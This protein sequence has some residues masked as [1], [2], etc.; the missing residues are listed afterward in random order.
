MGP[1]LLVSKPSFDVLGRPIR[2]K[3]VKLSL[4]SFRGKTMLTIPHLYLAA[5]VQYLGGIRST[6]HCRNEDLENLAGDFQAT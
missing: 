6:I 2:F 3:G 1:N 5:S 4:P